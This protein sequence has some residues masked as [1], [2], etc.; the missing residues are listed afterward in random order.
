VGESEKAV[1]ETFRKARS[2]APCIIFFD[3]IDAIAGER[4]RFAS[5]QVTEQVVSQLLTEMDGLEGLKDVILLAATNR[6]E[7][8]DAAL[9]RSGR[10]GRHIEIP[11]PD[12]NARREI[13]K[14]HLK[15]KPLKDDVSIEGLAEILDGYTG[16]DI[17]AISEEATL[18][19]IR[20]NIPVVNEKLKDLTEKQTQLEH[21]KSEQG[22]NF[23]EIKKI[24]SEIKEYKE[25]MV[26]K[27][28]ISNEEFE[29][30]IEKI[31]KD[32]DLAKRA[33]D[34]TL[35]AAEEMFR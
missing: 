20:K 26:E 33:H 14:I 13:F 16:A 17:Q 10:F 25:K 15:N 35:K 8:L 24:E 1:R 4:G 34:R 32:A 2:A 6:P 3:E 30:A 19:T 18:L 23:D 29:Q 31:L 22:S 11:M 7:L 5:S 9:L 27:V 12:L 21:L 28:F